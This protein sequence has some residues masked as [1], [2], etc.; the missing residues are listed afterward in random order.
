M[1]NYTVVEFS[2]PQVYKVAEGGESVFFCEKFIDWPDGATLGPQK[3]SSNIAASKK[4]EKIDV[5]KMYESSNE[6]PN[7]SYLPP[8]DDVPGSIEVSDYNVVVR[9]NFLG[10]S[11]NF[12]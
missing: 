4:Q 1:L 6:L 8:K 12:L 11:L 9:R 2:P 5:E 10:Y 7:L 3:F